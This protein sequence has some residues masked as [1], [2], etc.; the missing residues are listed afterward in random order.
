MLFPAQVLSENVADGL[1]E[2]GRTGGQV[3][4]GHQTEIRSTMLRLTERRR[5]S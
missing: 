5:R 3:V 1:E 2:F 4:F